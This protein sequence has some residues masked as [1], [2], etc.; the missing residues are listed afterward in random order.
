MGGFPLVGHA[1]EVG[2]GD[3]RR[4]IG[5]SGIRRG[6]LPV[7][8]VVGEL[9]GSDPLQCGAETVGIAWPRH[10]VAEGDLIHENVRHETGVIVLKALRRIR[11]VQA[12]GVAAVGQPSAQRAKDGH[13]LRDAVAL[14]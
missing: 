11:L 4:A 10:G 5:A 14:G 13:A 3:L 9:V 2:V 6:S 8:R 7:D 12:Q 1:V